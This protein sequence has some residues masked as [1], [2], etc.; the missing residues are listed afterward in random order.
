[1]FGKE[2]ADK[3]IKDLDDAIAIHGY[4][5][6]D[7]YRVILKWYGEKVKTNMPGEEKTLEERTQ[8]REEQRKKLRMKP[9]VGEQ[10]KQIQK[11]PPSRPGGR[12]C[13]K[14]RRPMSMRKIINNF[15]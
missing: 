12:M 2:C 7:H 8:A 5:Y 13:N 4:K 10:A 15:R 9:D 11:P 3:Y 1:M 6:K 14:G